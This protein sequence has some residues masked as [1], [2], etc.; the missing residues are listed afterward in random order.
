MKEVGG[1]GALAPSCWVQDK[2]EMKEVGR[3]T[4]A[5][6]LGTGQGGYEGGGR[7]HWRHLAGYRTR[8]V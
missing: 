5:I 1:G 8:W 7:G 3:G 6:L 2:L 4:G